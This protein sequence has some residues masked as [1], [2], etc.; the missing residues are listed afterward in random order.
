MSKGV[1]RGEYVQINKF[2][3]NIVCH[4]IDMGLFDKFSSI[5]SS[6]VDSGTNSVNNGINSFTK[7]I[8][9]GMDKLKGH[10][11]SIE[12]F[13]KIKSN[14]EKL[15]KKINELNRIQSLPSE[16]TSV[17]FKKLQE[18]YEKNP[19]FKIPTQD[20]IETDIKNQKNCTDANNYLQTQIDLIDQILGIVKEIP[21]CGVSKNSAI[22][23]QTNTIL[24]D[25]SN[26]IVN[27][28]TYMEKTK[29]QMDMYNSVKF[30]NQILLVLYCIIFIVIHF[31]FLVQYLQGVKRDAIADT[32]WVTVFFLYPYLIHY[33][34]ITLYSMISYI[35]SLIYGKAYVYQFDQLFMFTDFYTDPA[36]SDPNIK[37]SL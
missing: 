34:E 23:Y 12:E 3:F 13:D 29:H 36:V 31:L 19:N 8:D 21:N 15:Y 24:V 27:S 18:F 9:D 16:C 35:L 1:Q 10:C 28:N 26:N 20:T 11:D 17:D 30:V 7:K 4:Y 32:V 22:D 33:I 37:P 5:I 25:I 6:E 14:S 2:I